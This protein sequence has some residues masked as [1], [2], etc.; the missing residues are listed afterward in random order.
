VFRDY[1]AVNPESPLNAAS[2]AELA[3]FLAMKKGFRT[4]REVDELCRFFYFADDGVPMDAKAV[5]K[6][7]RKDDGAGLA[8]L[9][10]VRDVLAGVGEWR[11]EPLE[12]AVKAYCEGKGLGLGNVAQPVRVAI[13]GTT[14]SPPIFQS[15]EFLGRARAMGRI[16]RVTA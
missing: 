2:D 5:E 7:L 10:E 16:E 9:R 6:V 15:L 11:A 3:Q 8:V 13:S 1:L 4:L 12:A 14:V